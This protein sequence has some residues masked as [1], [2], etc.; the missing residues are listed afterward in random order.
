MCNNLV[1]CGGIC[2]EAVGV[3]CLTVLSL[4]I[5]SSSEQQLLLTV[6]FLHK[7]STKLRTLFTDIWVILDGKNGSGVPCTCTCLKAKL[8]KTMKIH[9]HGSIIWSIWEALWVRIAQIQKLLA[10]SHGVHNP[11]CCSSEHKNEDL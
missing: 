2:V 10:L 6:F 5:N 1:E 3:V 11:L 8:Q 4:L 9:S 7:Q